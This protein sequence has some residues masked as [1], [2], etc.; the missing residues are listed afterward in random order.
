[1]SREQDRR[2]REVDELRRALFWVQ[3]RLDAQRQFGPLFEPRAQAAARA[4]ASA[5]S[6]TAAG[7]SAPGAT[8]GPR[9]WR[10]FAFQRG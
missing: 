10:R 9:V 1:M 7:H 8:A 6:Q 4:A 5:G 3:A 2:R